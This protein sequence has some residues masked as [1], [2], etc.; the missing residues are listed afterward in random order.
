[1]IRGM[2]YLL[3]PIVAMMVGVTASSAVD[4]RNYPIGITD[5][6]IKIGQTMPHSG[7]AS[8]WGTLGLAEIALF[9][10][11]NDQ[12]G[13]HGRKINLISLDEC[14]QP[15]QDSRANTKAGRT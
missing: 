8:A 10:I 6:E 1:M 5:S 7:P 12:G 2:Q 13:I 11:I 14:L 3:A 15:T 4:Q 9:K